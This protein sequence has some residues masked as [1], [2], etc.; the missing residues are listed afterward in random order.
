MWLHNLR[1][2]QDQSN[3]KVQPVHPLLSNNKNS[4]YYPKSNT[5]STLNQFEYKN[6]RN[7]EQGFIFSNLKYNT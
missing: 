2:I 1:T 5:E 6:K 4:E 3:L 7:K